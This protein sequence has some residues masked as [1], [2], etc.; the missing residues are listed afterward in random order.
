MM[1][2]DLSPILSVETATRHKLGFCYIQQFSEIK[3][4]FFANLC[5]YNGPKNKS[6]NR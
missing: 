6:L 5:S 1:I 4:D 3:L 2:I